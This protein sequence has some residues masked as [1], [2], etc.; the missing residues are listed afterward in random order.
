MKKTWDKVILIGFRGAGKTTVGKLLAERLKLSFLDLDEEIQRRVGLSIKEMVERFGW[1]YFREREREVL[2]EL[3]NLKECV[4]A[5]GG[6]SILHDDLMEKLKSK[7]FIIYLKIS[8]DTAVERICKDS[9][10]EQT[11]P[12]LSN[13]SLAEE[14]ERMLKERSSLYQKFADIIIEADTM[15]LNRL[16]E[17]ILKHLGGKTWR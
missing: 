15:D 5:L 1:S 6:G 7:S 14:V 2:E 8:P 12:S 10:T 16:L 9:K 3:L 11:R 17:K 4:V 13:L